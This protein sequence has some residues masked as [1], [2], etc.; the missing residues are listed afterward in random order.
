MESEKLTY[1]EESYREK[2][3]AVVPRAFHTQM[4][5]PQYFKYE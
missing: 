5:V 1:A 3:F 4:Y 2:V